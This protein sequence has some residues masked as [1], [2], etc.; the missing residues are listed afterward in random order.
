VSPIAPTDASPRGI[1]RARRY[2]RGKS[3]GVV[4]TGPHGGSDMGPYNS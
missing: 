4:G 1:S 2:R 3:G